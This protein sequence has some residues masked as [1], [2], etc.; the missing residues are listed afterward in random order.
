MSFDAQRL[1]DLLPAVYRLRDA[2]L[3]GQI[4][5]RLGAAEQ[6][7]L[8]LLEAAGDGVD[9]A[10]RRRRDALRARRDN[11]PLAALLAV[12]AEQIAVLE[13]NLDQLY[14]DQF[15]E[16]CA[17]WA[18]PYIGDLIGYRTLH[19]RA[20]DADTRR[21]EVAH[22]IAFRRRK[23]TASMLEQLA[24]DVTG[25]KARAVEFFSLLATTQHMN[26]VRLANRVAPDL[27]DGDALAWIGSAF[28]AL[29]RTLDVRR[30]GSR[31]GRYNVPNVGLFLWRLDAHRLEASPA[32]PDPTDAAG[33]R[34]R[35]HP[36]GIDAP[37]VTWPEPEEEI[38]H[39]A[40]P[41]NVP[42]PV[43]RRLLRRHPARYYGPGRS[44]EVLLDGAVVPLAQIAVCNLA[45]DGAGGWAHD[46]PAGRVAIDPVLGRLVIAADIPAP[47]R[48]Q[49]TH[50]APAAGALGGGEY[51]RAATFTMP[52]VAPRRVPNDHATIQQAI[53]ALGG[54][55]VVEIRD[56]GIYREA[57]T[58]PVAAGGGI[59]LRAADGRRPTLVLTAPMTIR[60]GAGSAFAV[61]G[62]VV[63]GDL[64]QVPAANNG[65]RR[66]ALTHATLVPGRTLAPDGTP[67]LAGATSLEV[68]AADVEIALTRCITG[69]LRVA[70]GSTT[71]LVDSVVD[72]HAAAPAY[73]APGVGAAPGGVLTIEACTL[74]GPVNTVR[75]DASN[76]I[77]LGRVQVQRRQQGCVRF[78]YVPLDSLAPRRHRC[79]PGSGAEAANVPGFTS[80]RYGAPGYAQLGSRVPPAIARGADDESEM[81]ALHFLFQPQRETD[82]ATR[83]AEYL[84]I[85]LEAGVFHES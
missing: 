49:V 81:G 62:I 3:A 67:A 69:A 53:D 26:H 58:V 5:D 37:L 40:E 48:V 27:R 51:A 43:T 42:A 15:V 1:L 72:A 34:H 54:A 45:D 70:P 74:V 57:I 31:R 16:T 79:Q 63:A 66:L 76:A 47:G 59:E 71:A 17:P 68:E 14:D 12:F 21:A 19:G 75:L 22:T 7:E 84:R 44:L 6:T 41:I 77:L 20:P 32:V 18:V 28:D 2:A 61:N 11:G 4:P 52:A 13:E 65:L 55:G 80:L 73:A 64:L 39:L 33:R 9:P 56:N 30:I 10:Q 46:A 38:K 29:P 24:R 25:W 85:G 35:I 82:L 83:L 8:A 78:S 36:L 23:G 50:H 60:G